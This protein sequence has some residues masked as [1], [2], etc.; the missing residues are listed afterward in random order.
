MQKKLIFARI[1]NE[2]CILNRLKKTQS[3]QYNRVNKKKPDY[4]FCFL[5]ENKKQ[6]KDE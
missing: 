4:F 2:I 3:K 5:Y 6:K 1:L